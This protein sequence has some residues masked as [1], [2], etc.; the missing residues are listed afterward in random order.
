VAAD[1]TDIGT[2]AT[3]IANV[4][5]VAGNATNINNVAG[6][7]TNINTVA[8]I[9]ADVSTVAGDSADI[10]AVAADATDIGTVSTN[11]ANVN[12]VAGISA[13][14][15]AVAGDATDI[16]T[17]A[18]D[19][20]G[21][22]TIGTVATNIANVNAVGGDIANVNTVATNISSVNDFADKYRIGASD[23]TTSLDEGDLF[24]NTTTDT[25]KVYTGS[26]WEQGVTAGSGFL[27]TTGGA[28]TGN[29]SF[30]DN[31]KAIFGAGS[32]LQIY[33]DGFNSYIK[34]NGTGALNILGQ[35]Q[36]NLLNSAG[37]ETLAQF[38]TNSAVTL[39][40]NNAPKLATTAT[41]VDVTGTIT[42]DGVD[43]TCAAGDG[44]LALQAYHP[45]STSSR[46]IA[47][48]QSNVGGTQVDQMVIGCD[49]NVD[50]A[51]TVTADG[52]TVEG[53]GL[54][55][56]ATA[57]VEIKSFNPKLTFNDDSAVGAGSDKLIIQSVSGQSDGDYEF[58]LNNDQTSS[59]DQT[60]IKIK[61]NS[62][63]SFYDD[64]GVTQGFFWDASTQRLGLGTSS[65]SNALTLNSAAG[66][67]SGLRITSTEGS[68]FRIRAESA[69]T[70]ML[71]VD[72]GE[73]ML[74]G[75]GGTERM[76]IT[77]G[78]NVG[79]GT[80]SP[81]API[82]LKTSGSAELR[83]EQNGAGYGTIKS[84]DFGIL[85]LDA[86][87]GNTVASSSMRF[88]VDGSEAMRI[89][90]SGNV[91]IGTTSPSTALDVNGTVTATAFV[92]DGSG[93]TGVGGGNPPS[94]QVFTSS[95]TWTKP[96]GC[97]TIKVTVVGGGGGGGGARGL[98]GTSNAAGGGG[99]AGGSAI[100]YIDVTAV[101]S[102]SVTV[103]SGG[104][105]G[106]GASSGSAGGT[107]S[108]GAYC[109]GN[110]GGGGDGIATGTNHVAYGGSGG[111]SSGGDVNIK[112]GNGHAGQLYETDTPASGAGGV[113]LFGGGGDRA[114]SSSNG[115]AGSNGGGGSGAANRNSTT[116]R[117][118]GTGGNGIVVVEEY[119]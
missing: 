108:F 97:Q 71:N 75:T 27:P 5:S 114:L 38:V 46:D 103:G 37:D 80:S 36:I 29:V 25:L 34:E 113:S 33:H 83:L 2:V 104:A 32:D 51:G 110:G 107:S 87:A 55:D 92:G 118:G 49:G 48:F 100:E 79:I 73:S 53:D 62:D 10:Q 12:T 109:T 111:S 93:L 7:A 9:S 77:S 84:S 89:N 41:G 15:T 39:Y 17:V 102:V 31:D 116:E 13:N 52:L 67:A 57:T 115:S 1:G 91:G 101:S 82:H 28:M 3:N 72:S 23:P 6:N 16:G 66:G 70:T 47:K 88:R 42:A 26:A 86:D 64:T 50:I 18:A 45:T 94:I 90:S 78:G 35:G 30:G 63:I 22:D 112:G 76:R 74:F 95:G 21:S 54:F 96:S 14:V 65:P 61:G 11:I 99:G 24:Y 81:S 43:S 8:G 69:T 98:D 60:A 40:H 4:N 59:A 19:L 20:A 119:Y 56:S 85:Y 58:V 44:N 117:T 68:G 106:L 105:G